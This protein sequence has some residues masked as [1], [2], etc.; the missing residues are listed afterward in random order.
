MN[1]PETVKDRILIADE[2]VRGYICSLE[3]DLPED[4]A[5]IEKKA[6]T[7]GVPIIKKDAGQFLRY[8]IKDTAPE[9]ILEIGTAV[10]FSASLMNYWSDKEVR[11][12]TLE[13]MQERISEAKANFE[14][15]GISGRIRL[16]EGDAAENLEKLC[17]EG[18]YFDFVF[19]DAAKAQYGIYFESIKKLTKKGSV[20]LTDNILQ[21]GS[22]A[23]SK[24]SVTRRDRTIHKRM[25]EYIKTV[26]DDKCFVST[27]VPIGDGM[28]LT[29]KVRDND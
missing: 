9:S 1:Y 23:Q 17:E 7:D 27:I 26:F 22:V 13:K 6:L 8:V 5:E 14:K 4:I 28:L 10:G 24:F 29:K 3:P 20:I 16:I 19:L 18:T 21:E 25:R 11:I 2:N 15:L 12:T